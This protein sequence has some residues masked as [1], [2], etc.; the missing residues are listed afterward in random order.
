M[1]W[2]GLLKNLF[3]GI[4]VTAVTKAELV[5]LGSLA[6]QQVDPAFRPAPHSPVASGR[7]TRRLLGGHIFIL[8]RETRHDLSTYVF[9]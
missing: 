1:L 8:V 4:P 2:T 7:P 6:L 9:V 5:V 3:P